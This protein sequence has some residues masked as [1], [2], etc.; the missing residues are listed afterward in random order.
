MNAFQ[1]D[2]ISKM[3][4]VIALITA[5]EPSFDKEEEIKISTKYDWVCIKTRWTEI[6][7]NFDSCFTGTGWKLSDFKECRN[8]F[9]FRVWRFGE[10]RDTK[11]IPDENYLKLIFEKYK[12]K[13]PTAREMY[14]YYY[15]D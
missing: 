3:D 13:K 14:N 4:F 15:E 9:N 6:G 2:V 8:E 11:L 12:I 7:L 1:K 5:F 10:D